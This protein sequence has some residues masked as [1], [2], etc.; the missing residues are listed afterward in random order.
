M[1]DEKE[2]LKLAENYIADLGNTAS[3]K[4]IKSLSQESLQGQIHQINKEMDEDRNGIVVKCIKK[5]EDNAEIAGEGEVE[6]DENEG[7]GMDGP[8]GE[9]MDGP[10]GEEM[11]G[12]EGDDEEPM[13]GEDRPEGDSM[14][15]DASGPRRTGD[16][17]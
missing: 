3:E 7:E 16:A 6:G 1:V 13:E 8:E 5:I 9:G 2:A 11:D 4:M 12:P 10:E 17:D 14:G 15:D